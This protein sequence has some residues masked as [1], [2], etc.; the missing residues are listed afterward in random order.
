MQKLKLLVRYLKFLSHSTTKY[1][2]HSPFL[3]NLITKV[4]EDKT[5]YIEYQKVEDLKKSLIKNQDKI[6]ITDLGAGS[7]TGNNKQRTISRIA[8]NSSKG[9]KS[10]RLLYRISSEYKP[11]NI[12]ELGT[13]FG[14]S[15]SY[16]AIGNPESQV[17]TIEGCPNISTIASNNF[18]F[19]KI[20]NI[21]LY[22]GGFDKILPGILENL[23]ELNLVFFDGN[24]Q[25]EPTIKYF[26][27]C[28]EKATN[29]SCF[30]FDDIHWS[31]GMEEAWNYIL[32]NK[33]VT[34]SVDLFY[35]GM[36]FFKKELTKQNFAIRF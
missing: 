26:E 10:G 11:T 34:L 8:K 5:S 7:K 22:T 33:K 28:L 9:K 1:D 30:I 13:S 14:F 15:S 31:D 23:P 6:I 3:Y 18:D 32:Q 16:M 29:D 20:N 21:K 4:L 36:V 17:S 24:H 2:V 12:L 27:L 19:L 35:M 25:K